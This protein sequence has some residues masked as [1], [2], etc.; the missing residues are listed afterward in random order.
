MK[1]TPIDP[2]RVFD[3]GHGQKIE[4][5]DCAHIEL[6]PDEQVTFM[7]GSGAEYD[8]V[9]KT[10]GYYAAPSLNGRLK[11]FGLRA[12]L[13][14]GPDSKYYLLL[15]EQGREAAFH[16]YLDMEGLRIL[17][18]LDTEANLKALEQKGSGPKDEG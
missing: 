15:V 3:V 14:K 18:W 8:V 16:H 4:L 13:V 6:A 1:V 12:V 11:R 9:R 17:C 5:K 2:P 10:W 7:T